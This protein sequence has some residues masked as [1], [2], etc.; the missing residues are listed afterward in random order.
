MYSSSC[1]EGAYPNKSNFGLNAANATTATFGVLR[2]GLHEGFFNFLT[3]NFE[4]ISASFENL[5][6]KIVNIWS[7][8]VA[9]M[10]TSWVASGIFQA[11]K[12]FVDRG[13]SFFSTLGA[14]LGL[15]KF[16]K[17]ATLSHMS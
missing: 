12:E 8:V 10:V 7:D 6:L 16:E 17:R 5:G 3:G 1:Y 2:G 15:E 14:P 11:V 9:Q 4:G 13:T